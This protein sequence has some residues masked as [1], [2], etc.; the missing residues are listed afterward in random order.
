[1]IQNFSI[2]QSEIKLI[3]PNNCMIAADPVRRNFAIVYQSPAKLVSDSTFR[4]QPYK[5]RSLPHFDFI[6]LIVRR[7]CHGGG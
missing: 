3:R 7:E 2:E 4:R 5:I 6:A 1:M